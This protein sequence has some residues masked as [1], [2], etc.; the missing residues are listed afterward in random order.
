M[1]NSSVFCVL[2]VAFLPLMLRTS[3]NDI[4]DSNGLWCRMSMFLLDYLVEVNEMKFV[5]TVCGFAN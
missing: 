3:V 2:M 1:L 4:M 5:G